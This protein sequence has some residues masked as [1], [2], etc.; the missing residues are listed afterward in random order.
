M[1]QWVKVLAAKCHTYIALLETSIQS[2]SSRP[3]PPSKHC[4]S[5]EEWRRLRLDQ[6][7]NS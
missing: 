1:V 5:A 4:F 6:L 7:L 3:W 2:W